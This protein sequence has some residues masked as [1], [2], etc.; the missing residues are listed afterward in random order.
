MLNNKYLIINILFNASA[1]ECHADS[2]VQPLDCIVQPLDYTV[3][4][5]GLY[6]P[7]LGP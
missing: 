4:T 2:T 1:L 6:S 5:C 3:H 7:A